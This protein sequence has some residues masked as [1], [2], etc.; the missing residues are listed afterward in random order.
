MTECQLLMNHFTHDTI[1]HLGFSLPG[2]N[3]QYNFVS[4]MENYF[5]KENYKWL[6]YSH[7]H[8]KI[9]TEIIKQMQNADWL[10]PNQNH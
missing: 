10:F 4:E 1:F 2:F 5:I 8:Y 7:S 6:D 3:L 9:K